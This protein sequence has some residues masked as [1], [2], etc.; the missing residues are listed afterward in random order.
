MALK[1]IKDICFTMGF[2][3]VVL[4]GFL[5]AC[6]AIEVLG[7]IIILATLCCWPCCCALCLGLVASDPQHTQS[8]KS[9]RRKSMNTLSNGRYKKN[10]KK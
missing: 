6:C 9:Q 3:M 7:A 5:L 4:I 1:S 10:N 2:I 8:G